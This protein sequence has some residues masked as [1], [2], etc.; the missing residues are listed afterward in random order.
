MVAI[1]APYVFLEDY[2]PKEENR[3]IKH[4]YRDGHTHAMA[5]GTDA[6]N[7]IAENLFTVLKN[8]LRGGGC[9]TFISNIKARIEALN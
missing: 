8:H 1:Q 3:P 4:E 9:R 7:A 2:L 5:G 6:H